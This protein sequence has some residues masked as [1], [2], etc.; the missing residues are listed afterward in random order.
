MRTPPRWQGD[1]LRLATLALALL[2]IL[3][4]C[5]GRQAPQGTAEPPA[6]PEPPQQDG[7]D[8][9]TARLSDL[10]PPALGDPEAPIQL[11][12]FGDFQ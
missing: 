1:R 6:T 9:V 7:A 3:A 8:S 5:S 11:V 10:G 4:A 12:E 2:L